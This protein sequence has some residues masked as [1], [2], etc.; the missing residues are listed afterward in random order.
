MRERPSRNLYGDPA[1][2]P[3]VTD[4]FSEFSYA[5]AVT[6][7]IQSDL[8]AAGA[9][10]PIIPSL[11]AEKLVG[12]DAG[13]PGL[14]LFLQYKLPREMKGW[15]AKEWEDHGKKR[16]F[17]FPIY[18]RTPTDSQHNTMHAF[19]VKHPEAHVGYCAPG[20]VLQKDFTKHYVAKTVLAESLFLDVKKLGGIHDADSHVLTY[21]RNENGS[22]YYHI[23]HSRNHVQGESRD[24]RAELRARFT[25]RRRAP[26]P[27]TLHALEGMRMT[28][29]SLARRRHHAMEG[30]MDPD[31]HAAWDASLGL[32][33]ERRV[34]EPREVVEEL[35]Y[36]ALVEHGLHWLVVPDKPA[37]AQG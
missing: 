5:F 13:F 36:V 26:V 21:R 7:H 20:F 8:D 18:H 14:N 25:E 35:S 15:R 22:G 27:V 2:V 24:A 4:G 16:Y 29:L 17:R 37:P 12:Y 31:R 19:A 9:G 23:R 11:Q 6:H 1:C 33:E 34:R 10:P 30:H 32:M 28:L 3:R